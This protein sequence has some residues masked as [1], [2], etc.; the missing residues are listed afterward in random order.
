[1][2]ATTKQRTYCSV[3]ASRCGVVATVEDGRLVSVTPDL[4]HPI[5]GFCVKGSTSPELVYNAGRLRYPMRRTTPKSSADPGWR[6]ISWD[7][8]MTEVA[9][10][11]R[12]VRDESGAEA[13]AFHRPAPGGSSATD[14]VGFFERLTE[15]FG[16]PNVMGSTHICQWARD[17]GSTYTYG[18]GLPTPHYE[19]AETILIWGHNPANSAVQNWHRILAAKRRGARLVVVDPRRTETASR[20]DLWVRVRPGSDAALALGVINQLIA[21]RRFDAL[22]V[23][24][25][26]NAP[27]LVDL[28][29]GRLL[30]AGTVFGGD[31]QAYVVRDR[32]TGALTPIDVAVDP[33]AWPADPDLFASLDI[34]AGGDAGAGRT[35]RAS[36]VLQ[37]LAQR[38]SEFDPQTVE[39]LC[40]VGPSAL[41]V[42]ADAIAA[43]GPLCYY[44]YNGVEQHVD[45]AQT[46]RAL[47]SLYAL[48]G[49]LESAGGNVSLA[50]PRGSAGLL[51]QAQRAKR[52]GLDSRPLGAPLRAAQSYNVYDAV[53]DGNP[54]HVRALVAFGGDLLIQAPDSERGRE[55]LSALDFF[56]QIDMFETPTGRLADILLPAATAWE[57]PALMTASVGR[58]AKSFAQ[59]RPPIVAPMFEARPDIEVIFDLAVRLGLGEHFAGGSVEAAFDAQLAGLGLTVDELRA[60]PEGLT[61]EK[62][63]V[64]RRYAE[65]DGAGHV[66]GFATPSRKV[67]LYSET[68]LEH[69][70]DP[71]PDGRRVGSVSD[72][73]PLLLTSHKLVHFLHGQ[74][75]GIPG[76]RKRVPE[77]YVEINPATAVAHGI[78]EGDKVRIVTASGSVSNFVARLTD[79][80]GREAIATQTGWWEP[81]E[82]LGLP[83]YD[84]FASSGA[85]INLIMSANDLDPISGS[86]PVKSYPCRIEK[87]AG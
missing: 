17:S 49:W 11:L 55:A 35:I 19:A 79:D 66:T 86:I 9:G 29:T 5:K 83:G 62:T 51:P 57:S 73:F 82:E 53:L 26:T 30:R 78:A 70:Y 42:L 36:T 38:A 13:V 40:G 50:A 63:P 67:E 4:D 77:P 85:N 80:L 64:F 31:S 25:W 75:R 39:R 59:Y 28:D 7:E 52:L 18:S 8:A 37:L 84:P 54:Y 33:S 81:C 72:E 14:W 34:P 45:T 12:E 87:V 65:T 68:F 46:N 47:C 44:T 76:L 43:P 48:T 60:A 22:F 2:T 58:E 6:R 74:G 27:F 61:V 56:V 23:A 10:R 20:A 71:L 15:A 24:G 21:D 16:T 1:M 3:C 32:A 41:R 69:G